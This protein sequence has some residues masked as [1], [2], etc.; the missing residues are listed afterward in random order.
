M[1]LK[2]LC[3][4]DGTI[5]VED[6]SVI[7]LEHFAE[8]PWQQYE[9]MLEAGE[10]TTEQGL[11]LEFGLVKSSKDQ[12]LAKIKDLIVIRNG[13]EEFVQFC[14]RQDL[15]LIIVSAGL[16]FVIEFVQKQLGINLPV[17]S[18]H[19]VFGDG[20]SFTFP[21]RYFPDSE[22][23][24]SDL[25]KHYQG[26]DNKVIFIGDGGSDF[27]GAKYA[28]YVFAVEN[29]SLSNYLQSLSKQGLYE[30]NSFIEIENQVTK[31]VASI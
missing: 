19:T 2:I 12:I 7:V 11:P 5:A 21:V 20:I 29:Q 18:P 31:I 17:V 8:G 9:D 1:K 23:F 26:V 3:D 14:K 10:I 30:F 16:D 4:F 15:E 13:F 27:Q 25:V 28:D 6:I 22:D 24:K